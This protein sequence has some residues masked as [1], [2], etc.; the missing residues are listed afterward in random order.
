MPFLF[1]MVRN[2]VS[3]SFLSWNYP[4][5][6]DISA[7]G[8]DLLFSGRVVGALLSV[9]IGYSVLC[10]RHCYIIPLLNLSKHNTNEIY[11]L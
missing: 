7:L 2:Y 8:C 1:S 6:T 3:L 10:F 5:V 9:C 4:F 11:I